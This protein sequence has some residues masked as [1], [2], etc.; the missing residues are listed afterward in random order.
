MFTA[1]CD[2]GLF[3]VIAFS[4]HFVRKAIVVN[5]SEPMASFATMPLTDTQVE[6][7]KVLLTTPYTI[8]HKGP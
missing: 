8:R 3:E 5:C 7:S 4:Q 6:F 2:N 1:N